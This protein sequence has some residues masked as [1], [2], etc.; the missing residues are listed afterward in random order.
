MSE[1]NTDS[2]T[3]AASE[4]PLR[5]VAQAEAGEAGSLADGMM[6]VDTVP[7][8][9][10]TPTPR[11]ASTALD[12]TATRVVADGASALD[13]PAPMEFDGSSDSSDNGSALTTRANAAIDEQLL[14]V[15]PSVAEVAEAGAV[16]AAAVELAVPVAACVPDPM[17]GVDDS[18]WKTTWPTNELIICG[19]L[20][21]QI[22]QTPTVDGVSRM[23]AAV[24]IT[25]IDAVTGATGTIARVPIHILPLAAGF[26]P[27]FNEIAR[28]RKQ[29][30]RLQPI[31][32][33]LRGVCK[34]LADKDPRF[35]KVRWSTL[36]G[37]EISQVQR[38]DRQADQYGRWRGMGIVSGLRSYAINGVQYLRVTLNVIA[39]KP[40]ARLR[41]TS[42]QCDQVDVL[43]WSGHAHLQRFRR[44]GQRLLV[45]A[46]VSAH[47]HVLHPNHPDLE[48]LEAEVKAR[49]QVVR[50]SLLIATLGEFP[51][52][53]AADEFAAW[54]RAGRPA[55]QG[56]SGGQT[57]RQNQRMPRR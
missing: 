36:F 2:R 12:D 15:Q 39:T 49:L 23:R 53:A 7:P 37:M 24:D 4:T 33:E 10:G 44:L 3:L 25:E 51:D 22:S 17:T 9:E 42:A 8:R 50:Q 29:R 30:Q 14:L 32:V 20:V 26:G 35:A 41:G 19:F 13:A 28:A 11:A 31:P 55:A 40:K 6:G 57:E 18:Q 5:G 45:E 16:L 46:E 56:R 52:Q 54:G 34:R 47:T 43:V 27:V 21:P 48:G 38:M 1:L